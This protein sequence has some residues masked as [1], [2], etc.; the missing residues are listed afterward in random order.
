M[1]LG[2]NLSPLPE[3]KRNSMLVK[4]QIYKQVRHPL[5]LSLLIMS[6]SIAIFFLSLNHFILFIILSIVL[7]NKAHNEEI[8]LQKKFKHYNK[9]IND[10]PAIINGLIFFDWRE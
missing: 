6:L 7:I 2:R 9:Y 5:Y 3:P 4:T 1:T 8:R 10:T